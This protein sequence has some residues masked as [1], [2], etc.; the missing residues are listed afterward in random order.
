MR[1]EQEIK[2]AN[3]AIKWITLWR[4]GV[5]LEGNEIT[6]HTFNDLMY[7]IVWGRPI[8]IKP[9]QEEK[10]EKSFLSLSEWRSRHIPD[11]VACPV[12]NEDRKHCTEENCYLYQMQIKPSKLRPWRTQE[13]VPV[14]AMIKDKDGDLIGIILWAN[15]YG[16]TTSEFG[17]SYRDCAK[18]KVWRRT[19]KDQWQEC[20]VKE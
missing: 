10:E 19:E 5:E 18:K 4:D 13:E 7:S 8:R 16:I 2:Q 17:Y 14:G 6:I 20:G 12:G 1:T 11:C 3:E 15:A 9:G